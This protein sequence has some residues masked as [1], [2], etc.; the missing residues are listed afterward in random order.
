MER[1]SMSH[2]YSRIGV[3][4]RL[5]GGR[6]GDGLGYLVEGPS[7]YYPNI[8][9]CIRYTSVIAILNCVGVVSLESV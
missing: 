6:F 7:E 2:E 4:S 5:C 8:Y 9:I 1:R 3:L